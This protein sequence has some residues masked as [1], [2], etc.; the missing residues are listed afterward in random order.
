MSDWEASDNEEVEKPTVSAAAVS[1][2][3]KNKWADEDADEEVKEDWEASESEEEKPK[4]ETTKPK[5]PVRNKGIT[6]MKIAEKEAEEALRL[7]EQEALAEQAADPVLR[8]K[9][10]QTRTIQADMENARGLFGDAVISNPNSSEDPMK[11]NPKTKDEFEAMSS[12]LAQ[13]IISK[14]G[15]KPLYPLFVEHFFRQLSEPLGDVQTRKTASILTTIANE[16][17]RAAK[18][19]KKGK[20]KQKPTL[21]GGGAS[22]VAKGGRGVGAD[23]EAYDQALDDEF[24]DFM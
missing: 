4:N 24:D 1:A 3:K 16:K 7:A 21:G 15:N 19:A 9:L 8:K 14:H 11:M 18:D 10:E 2:I 5:G 17:Q 22:T 6:K 13:L 12:L 23:L 20:G